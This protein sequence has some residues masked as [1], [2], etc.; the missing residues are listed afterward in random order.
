[1]SD[2]QKIRDISNDPL[3]RER[4]INAQKEDQEL[5]LR[6][7]RS[8]SAEEAKNIPVC[9]FTKDKVLMRKWRPPDVA[10]EDEWKV[11]YQL[12]VPEEYWKEAM[13]LARGSPMAGHLRANKTYDMILLYLY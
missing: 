3:T 10:A 4:L 6:C 5:A 13:S 2:G 8:F 1:M 7:S 12:V 11:V 9:Y